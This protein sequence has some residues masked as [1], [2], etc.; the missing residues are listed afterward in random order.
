MNDEP[1]TGFESKDPK[2]AAAAS[3]RKGNYSMLQMAFYQQYFDVST[4]EV[5][6]RILGSMFPRLDKASE[7]YE[8]IRAN[9]DLYGPFWISTTLIFTIAI[10]GNMYN[11]LSNFGGPFSW[12]TDFHKRMMSSSSQPS[13]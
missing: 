6:N 10:G 5:R 7:F 13:F 9:P 4:K 3:S 12:H 11:F 8:S 2:A 1:A